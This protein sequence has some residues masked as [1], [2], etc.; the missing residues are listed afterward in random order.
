MTAA[1]R[2]VMRRLQA[3][4]REQQRLRADVREPWQAP[5]SSTAS[6]VATNVFAG[7]ITSSP[8][9]MP[10]P[11]KVSWSASV[12]FATPSACGTWQ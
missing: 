5:A 8:G 1:V 6:A 9:P 2:G 10:S 11:V 4:G 12:P 7:T 3:L